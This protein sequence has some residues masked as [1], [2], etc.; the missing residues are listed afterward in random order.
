MLKALKQLVIAVDF[1]SWIQSSIS[2]VQIKVKA[3]NSLKWIVEHLY[4]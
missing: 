4:K 1:E 3:L 2:L